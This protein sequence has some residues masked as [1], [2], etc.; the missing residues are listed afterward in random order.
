[1]RRPSLVPR[2]AAVLLALSCPAAAAFVSTDARASV[3]IAVT[4]ESLLTES[5]AAAVVTPVEARSVWE[6][7]RVYTY[8]RVRVDRPIAGGLSANG[9]AWVRTMGGVVGKI[10]QIVEGEAV[11]VTGRSSLL[12]LRA[13][14]AGTLDV[15]A[16]GQGQFPVVADVDP[17]K[18]A[19]L[20]RSHSVGALL[21]PRATTATPLLAADAL[22]GRVVED[23]VRDIAGAWSRTHAG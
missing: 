4:W 1:M 2:A 3:S 23:A 13:G 22:H 18:P 19:H 10:G 8:T 11:L 6:G 14:P 5:T 16:R 21:P 12:F 9:D 7:G 20:V 17:A 15:T